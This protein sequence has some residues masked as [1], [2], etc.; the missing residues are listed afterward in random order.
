MT[1]TNTFLVPPILREAVLQ[2]RPVEGER[3]LVITR[4]RRWPN[5]WQVRQS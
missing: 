1:K 5:C 2:A 3:V 4:A